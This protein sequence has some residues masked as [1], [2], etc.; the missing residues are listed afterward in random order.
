MKDFFVTAIWTAAFVVFLFGLA[1]LTA[2][3]DATRIAAYCIE[4]PEKC[5]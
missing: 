4:H 2:C 3:S 1:L 5:D